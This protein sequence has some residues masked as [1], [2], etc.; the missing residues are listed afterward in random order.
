MRQSWVSLTRV[1]WPIIF[2]MDVAPRHLR[3]FMVLAELHTLSETAAVLHVSQ[4]TVSRHLA[5]LERQIGT[6][7]AVR[8]GNHMRLT[9]AGRA[10]AIDARQILD[11]QGRM[12][13]AVRQRAMY[14][15]TLTIAV[16]CPVAPLAGMALLAKLRSLLPESNPVAMSTD[17]FDLLAAVGDGRADV[18]LTWLPVDAQPPDGIRYANLGP[19]SVVVLL[20]SDDRLAFRHTVT[21]ADLGARRVVGISPR[22]RLTRW[23][24]RAWGRGLPAASDS[25]EVPDLPAVLD[26]VATS[27][28]AALLPHG[29]VDLQERSDVVEVELQG[30]HPR[31]LSLVWS[32]TAPP[33]VQDAL[34]ASAW[35]I[36]EGQRYEISNEN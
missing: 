34:V 19:G 33:V 11:M 18:A 6:K 12:L 26:V 28:R 20:A 31:A 15:N 3:S 22:D 35:H 7:L 23:W 1:R 16:P 17:F 10:V 27:G 4:S 29:L 36:V 13:G 2:D 25:I 5:A 8:A 21:T 24:W 30:P 32:S 14:S 9:S